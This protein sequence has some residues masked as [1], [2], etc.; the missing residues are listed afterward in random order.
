MN[1]R[2]FLQTTGSAMLA[3]PLIFSKS[4]AFA[5]SLS[6]LSIAKHT[7]ASTVDISSGTPDM[8]INRWALDL[9]VD[10]M[11]L[12]LTGKPTVGQAW[13]SIF[14]AGSLSAQ[15]KIGIKFNTGGDVYN[16]YHDD[17]PARMCP[18]AV[19]A[20]VVEAIV[21]GLT[22]MLDGTFPIE[23]ITA[24]DKQVNDPRYHNGVAENLGMVN[25]GF[26]PSQKPVNQCYAYQNVPGAYNVL[27]V[28]VRSPTVMA[29]MPT[30]QAGSSV[31]V[32]QV[33][34]PPL[35]HS[36]FWIDLFMPRDHP[37][38]GYTGALKNCYGCTDNCAG[39]HPSGNAG[40]I[41]E[42]IPDFLENLKAITPCV[43][44]V[45]DA[46]AG[47]YDNMTECFYP[48]IMA[49]CADPLT[50]DYYTLERV[51]EARAQTGFTAPITTGPGKNADGHANAYYL[52]LAQQ[53]KYSLGNFNAGNQI[54]TDLSTGLRGLPSQPSLDVPH[55]R[56]AQLSRFGDGWRLAV[57]LDASGRNHRIESNVI[58]VYGRPVRD[59]PTGSTRSSR[60]DIEWDGR[61]GNGLR[62]PSGVYIVRVKIN[63]RAG[64]QS[65][66]I[67]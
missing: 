50:I 59:L 57:V 35:V 61:G 51:N 33:V 48:N 26:P 22:Q 14:P 8:T 11:I 9:M 7:L 32:P 39:T 54:F 24:F 49:A 30:F 67:A 34:V 40:L 18:W 29:G 55:G 60:Y 28:D 16:L 58:D 45:V 4:K 5:Q 19:K 46:L 66:R 44:G 47:N 37:A 56:I 17:K 1:R 41:H 52:A 65:I 2:S 42:C 13:E 36:D 21:S 31:R 38:A 64:Y 62:V 23:N 10:K 25:Q 43:L 15:T 27:L 63:G 6:A 12:Q 53:T 20:P 3:G